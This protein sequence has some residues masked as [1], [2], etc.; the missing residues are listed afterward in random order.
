MKKTI[1][2]LGAVI[3]F[4]FALTPAFA[5]DNRFSLGAEL[6]LPM[7]SFGDAAGIGFGVSGRIEHPLGDNVGLCLT[8][9]W[10]TFG[11]KDNSGVTETM[12]PIQA[13]IK[14]Y[15][16]ENQNGLYGMVDLGVHS[17]TSKVD[18]L[19]TTISS[20]VSK[21]SYAPEI[22]YHLANI[23]LGLRYQLIATD[24]STTSYLGV[25]VAYVFGG[26]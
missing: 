24:G 3:A 4:V 5:E 20:S 11:E 25:R 1:I 15:F 16:T 10:L 2:K 9:G 7:G 14:Y 13:G 18:F 6:A 12:I 17:L 22:G 26:K 21:L 19:G 23:D 8:V